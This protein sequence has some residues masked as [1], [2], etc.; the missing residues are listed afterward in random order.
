MVREHYAP[1]NIVERIPLKENPIV[2]IQ[3]EEFKDILEFF[4]RKKS[5][6]HYYF[7][8]FLKLTGFR[9]SEALNLEWNDIDFAANR[10]K[11]KNQKGKRVDLFPLYPKVRGVM[12]KLPREGERIFSFKN[13]DSLKFWNRA[14]EKLGYSYTLHNI[15]KT[16]AT[17]LVN[18][19]VSVFDA[20]KLLRH[21]NIS[22][23][24]K[25]YTFA[26]LSRIG[27]EAEKIFA[28]KD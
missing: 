11:L 12:E 2:Y 18:G 22:T 17:E 1:E 3:P 14:M 8:M 16:F 24:M 20:M 5:L 13:K 9:V 26:D 28:E 23:T 15:R 25:Y 6:E 21:R 19:S 4:K 10:I 27:N 7:I